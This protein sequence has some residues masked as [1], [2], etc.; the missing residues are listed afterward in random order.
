MEA[1]DN[2]IPVSQAAAQLGISL[3]A[4]RKRLQRGQLRAYKVEGEWRVVLPVQPGPIPESYGPGTPSP[5]DSG[6]DTAVLQGQVEAL[7]RA[8]A[9]LAVAL[10][11]SQQGE[12]ELRRLLAVAL[13]PVA[14]LPAPRAETAGEQP[15]TVEPAERPARRWWAF[16]R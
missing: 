16:W 1:L 7:T 6:Q 8:N 10:E 14:P 13:Q 12:A 15:V 2:G 3:A 9:R 4:M 11:R 5:M